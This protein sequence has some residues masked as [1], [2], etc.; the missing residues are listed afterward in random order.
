MRILLKNK[1]NDVL[2]SEGV[3]VSDLYDEIADLFDVSLCDVGF[4]VAL[5]FL[6]VDCLQ[7][8]HAFAEGGRISIYQHGWLIMD[9]RNG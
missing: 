8:N 3:L 6:K 7:L 5:E 4:C 9:Q 2:L 1:S